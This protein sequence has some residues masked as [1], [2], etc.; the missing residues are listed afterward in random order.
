MGAAVLF[1]SVQEREWYPSWLV[2]CEISGYAE[3][4]RVCVQ[5]QIK[6]HAGADPAEAEAEAEAVRRILVSEIHEL[7]AAGGAGLK[8]PVQRIHDGREYTLLFR[9]IALGMLRHGVSS[10][11]VSCRGG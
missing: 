2:V 10:N 4:I 1:L 8:F 11:N 9:A 3:P 5:A 7:E 6:R